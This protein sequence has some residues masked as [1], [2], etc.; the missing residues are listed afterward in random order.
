M[1]KQRRTDGLRLDRNGAETGRGAVKLFLL[2]QGFRRN[3]P[4][5]FGFVAARELLRHTCPHPANNP[6]PPI[7][8]AAP[9][10]RQYPRAPAAKGANAAENPAAPYLE[11]R[12]QEGRV[13]KPQSSEYQEWKQNHI[14]DVTELAPSG[15]I[16]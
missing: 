8:T 4:L 7:L 6:P 5:R 13:A 1:L 16:R 11:L 14:R 12:R 9:Y 10:P 2:G 3:H 15:N